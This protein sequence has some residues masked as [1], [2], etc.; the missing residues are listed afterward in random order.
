MEHIQTSENGIYTCPYCGVK[1][2]INPTNDEL[3]NGRMKEVCPACSGEMD[4][5]ISDIPCHVCE[6]AGP[7][8]EC[9]A[10]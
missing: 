5:Y 3:E 7:C 2:E 1:L 10:A 9:D 6:G 8:G 4:F